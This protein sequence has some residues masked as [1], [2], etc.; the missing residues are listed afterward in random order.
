MKFSNNLRLFFCVFWYLQVITA[1]KETTSVTYEGIGTFHPEFYGPTIFSHQYLPQSPNLLEPIFYLY[2]RRNPND[3]VRL[4]WNDTAQL[5]EQ[6]VHFNESLQTK[7]IVH[8]FVQRF[9]IEWVHEM[10]SRYLSYRDLNV[11]VLDWSRGNRP[12]YGQAS[13]NTRVVGAMIAIQ[14]RL[15]CSLKNITA[16]SFHILGH[17][18][19][20]H[21]AGF[22]GKYLNGSLGQITGFD[23][24]GPGFENVSGKRGLWA[25]DAAFVD[26]IHTDASRL[27]KADP[28]GHVDIYP[29]GGQNQPGC[30]YMS[31]FFFKGIKRG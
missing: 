10:K 27:G 29:N 8:G 11:I 19:G 20:A 3:P 2:T 16:D 18:L 12:P 24:A 21:V 7:M 5:S 1:T 30:D 14:I 23:P 31:V 13:A 28:S 17:S 25:S 6:L 9:T 4:N 22:A 15:L 26:V